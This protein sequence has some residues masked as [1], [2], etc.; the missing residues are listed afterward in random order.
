[1]VLVQY[2]QYHFKE[3]T[4]AF[5][6]EAGESISDDVLGICA[7]QLLSKHCEE[8][9]EVDGTWCF[10]HHGLKVFICGVFT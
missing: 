5:L 8:H 10:V 4:C 6:V 1:M 9:G 3:I 7:I 2:V